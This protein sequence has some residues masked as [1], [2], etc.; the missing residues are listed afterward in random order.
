M[1]SN[2]RKKN[3]AE[4]AIN[5]LPEAKDKA[6]GVLENLSQNMI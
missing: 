6:G 3:Q 5:M 1:L 2:T 4:K